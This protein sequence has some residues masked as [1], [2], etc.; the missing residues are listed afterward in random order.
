[1]KKTISV[2]CTVILLPIITS[3]VAGYVSEPFRVWCRD[4]IVIKKCCYI[5]LGIVLVATAILSYFFCKQKLEHKKD[6]EKKQSSYF[7]GIE[8]KFKEIV[9]DID[10]LQSMQLY[11]YRLSAHGKEENIIINYVCGYSDVNI[12]INAIQ[13]DYYSIPRELFR[14][15]NE[16]A[17]KYNIWL[18]QQGIQAQS[19][20]HQYKEI[21]NKI[22]NDLEYTLL[23][24]KSTDEEK[25][26]LYRLLRAQK[27]NLTESKLIDFVLDKSYHEYERDLLSYKRTGLLPSVFFEDTRFFR[28][29]SNS[30]KN[31]RIYMTCRW[32]SKKGKRGILLFA[33]DG[34]IVSFSKGIQ[35]VENDIEHAL[36]TWL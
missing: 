20:F 32:H 4:T 21:G 11:Q 10:Y 12:S 16:A 25:C 13:Q 15:Y 28:N 22:S 17:Q 1:M 19:I 23:K 31:G 9:D 2:V 14:R 29:V 8:S 36:N 7:E 34:N 24:E 5:V 35:E 27:S 26:T 30:S 6:V 33:L 18:T 3:L